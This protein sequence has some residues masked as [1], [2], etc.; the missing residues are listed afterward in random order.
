MCATHIAVHLEILDTPI[1][2]KKKK[3][4]K[5]GKKKKWKKENQKKKKRERQRGHIMW[6]QKRQ[7]LWIFEIRIYMPW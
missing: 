1:S 5:G 4:K 6:I 7:Y 2:K 3:K